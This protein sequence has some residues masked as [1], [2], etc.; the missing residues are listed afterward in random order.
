MV[1]R[2]RSCHTASLSSWHWFSDLLHLMC[3]GPMLQTKF[4]SEDFR[5]LIAVGKDAASLSCF[6]NLFARDK[7]PLRPICA[8]LSDRRTFT[9]ACHN[10]GWKSY[11]PKRITTLLRP[12][13]HHMYL[14]PLE[15]FLRRQS[16]CFCN[17]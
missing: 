10:K 13:Q 6:F 15:Y 17:M 4:R 16:S 14:P 3:H 7:S 1:S 2:L 8:R 11:Q 5:A 12:Q 9:I